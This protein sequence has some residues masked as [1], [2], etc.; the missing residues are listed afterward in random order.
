MVRAF[1]EGFNGEIVTIANLSFPVTKEIII[2]ATSFPIEGEWWFKN[3]TLIGIDIEF[4][5]KDEHRDEDW[6]Q[7][8]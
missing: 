3:Q 2:E 8:V 5:L 6:R 7:N 4:F 1:A